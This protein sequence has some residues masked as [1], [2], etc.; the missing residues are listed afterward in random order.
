MSISSWAFE[1]FLFTKKDE[2]AITPS[3]YQLALD[4]SVPVWDDT[5]FPRGVHPYV[6]VE[7]TD[8]PFYLL[9]RLHPYHVEGKVIPTAW[10]V[11]DCDA[12]AKELCEALNKL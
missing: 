12:R 8:P 5:K 6:Q 2:D 3:M 7:K 11:I 1:V 9:Y 10:S 4:S